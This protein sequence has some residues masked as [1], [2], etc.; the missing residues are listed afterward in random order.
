MGKVIVDNVKYVYAAA[1][2]C[3]PAAAIPP[4]FHVGDTVLVERTGDDNIRVELEIVDE[5]AGHFD[6]RVVDSTEDLG[7]GIGVIFFYR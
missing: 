4:I 3:K 5:V 2:G 7:V 6:G 1:Q